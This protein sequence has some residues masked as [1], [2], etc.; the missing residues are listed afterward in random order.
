MSLLMANRGLIKSGVVV[1]TAFKLTINTALGTGDNFQLPLPSGE[2]Y[3]F[4]V[5]WGDS[6][7]DTITVYNQAETLHTY[8]GAFNGQ[9]SISGKCGGWA[10]NNGGDKLTVVSVDNWGDVEFE[11][12]N[13]GFYG[14]SNLISAPSG[15]KYNGTVLG[16]MFRECTSLINLDVSD[17]D[18]SNI[19]SLVHFV[20]NC[21]SLSSLDVSGWDVSNVLS[22]SNFMALSAI[23]SL[24]VSEW[25]TTNLTN[26]SNFAFSATSLA[27]LNVSGWDISDVTTT[28]FMVRNTALVTFN[29]DSWDTSSITNCTA[30][31]RDCTSLTSSFDNTLWWNRTIPIATFANC[32]QNA[33]NISNYASIPAAW[34]GGGA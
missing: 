33:L 22:M 18:I 19:I 29:T 30:M 13:F 12:L 3:N 16:S 14:C 28:F 9:I 11:S 23:V 8:S 20:Y 25:T 7:Q 1:D 24:D 6:S 2:T 31:A 17:W 21:N 34:G 27:T 15:L 26:L 4:I 10:Q 5:D 32:F